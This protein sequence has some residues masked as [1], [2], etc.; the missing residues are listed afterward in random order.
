M[1]FLGLDEIHHVKCLSIVPCALYILKKLPV[2]YRIL[3]QYT[4]RYLNWYF[5]IV[6]C[7]YEGC[8]YVIIK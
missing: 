3:P 4:K 2:Y 5:Q 7:N 1:L 6:G 8:K